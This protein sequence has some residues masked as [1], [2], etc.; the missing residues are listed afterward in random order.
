MIR[1]EFTENTEL[2]ENRDK[3]LAEVHPMKDTARLYNDFD[4]EITGR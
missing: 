3:C 1:L 4:D 2:L